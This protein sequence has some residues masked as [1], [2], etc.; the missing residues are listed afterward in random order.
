MLGS[1]AA[2]VWQESQARVVVKCPLDLPVAE[3]PLW[4]VAQLPGVTL[5]WLNVEGSQALVR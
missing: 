5:V 1:Q 3:V 2:V 4:Q